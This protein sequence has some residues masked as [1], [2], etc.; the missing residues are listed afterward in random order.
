M[1]SIVAKRSNQ[2]A[3]QNAGSRPEPPS[4]SSASTASVRSVGISL[5]LRPPLARVVGR[6]EKTST[7]TTTSPLPSPTPPSTNPTDAE[8]LSECSLN[9]AQNEPTPRGEMLARCLAVLEGGFGLT[10]EREQLLDSVREVR[11]RPGQTLLSAKQTAIG[12]YVVEEGGLEVLSPNEDV[13]LGVLGVGDFCGELSSFF[14]TPCTAT[15]RA[16]WGLR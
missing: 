14:H 5:P 9:D 11:C 8:S 3:G 2:D 16:Q 1:G 15:V 7:A 12:V 10:F 13:V 4:R 6:R